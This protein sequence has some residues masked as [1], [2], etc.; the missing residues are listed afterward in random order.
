MARSETSGIPPS[1]NAAQIIRRERR[2]SLI[3]SNENAQT[4]EL[5]RA[6]L[7]S[8]KRSGKPRLVRQDPPIGQAMAPERSDKLPRAVR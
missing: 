2:F 8:P 7:R 4:G 6:S 3:F 1:R 5:H